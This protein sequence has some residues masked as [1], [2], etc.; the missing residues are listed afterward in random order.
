MSLWDFFFPAVLEHILL[1]ITMLWEPFA[2]L[3]GGGRCKPLSHSVNCIYVQHQP[4]KC[5]MCPIEDWCLPNDTSYRQDVYK[6]IEYAQQCLWMWIWTV[7]AIHRTLSAKRCSDRGRCTEMSWYVNEQINIR[8]YSF[9][10]STCVIITL[11]PGWMNNSFKD[12]VCRSS[13]PPQEV[14]CQGW[15][16]PGDQVCTWDTWGT[17]LQLPI[18]LAYCMQPCAR[19]L[20]SSVCPDRVWGSLPLVVRSVWDHAFTSQ[21]SM[22]V[23]GCLC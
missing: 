3:G 19:V 10:M 17:T 5:P 6:W 8:L 14:E 12:S 22:H 7:V 2:P 1:R 15:L 21:V 16:L 18:R 4:S 23:Q 11:L 20:M 13:N 9:C